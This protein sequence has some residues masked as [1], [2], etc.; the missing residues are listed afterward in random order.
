MSQ[1][2][3]STCSQ[4]QA[5]DSGTQVTF[6]DNTCF[7]SSNDTVTMEAVSQRDG[8]MVIRQSRQQPT[9]ALAATTAAKQ[10]PELWHRRFG[11]LGYDNLFK[12]KNKHMVEGISV[13]AE[14]FKEQQQQKPFCEECTLAKQHRLPF[15][16]S[17]SSSSSL[18][19][20]V[21]MDVCGP[22]QVK[23]TGDARDLATFIDD[24]SRLC[25][26]VPLG[27]KSEAAQAVRA[28]ISLWET[29]TGHRLK[30]VHTDRGTDYVNSELETYFSD[31]GVIHN[32]TAPYTPEQNGVAERFNHTLTKW[33]RSMLLDAKL[34]SEHWADAASTATYVKNRS[35]SSH[36]S[37]TP[38]ELFFGRKPDVS[39]MRVFGSKAYVHVPKQL[40]R[41]LD[42][43][44]TVG[45]FIGYEPNTKAYRV[46][47]DS[48][49]V[50]IS[51]DVIFLERVPSAANKAAAKEAEHANNQVGAGVPDSPITVQEDNSEADSTGIDL[52]P[53]YSTDSEAEE[54]ATQAA[55]E[56]AEPAAE[57]TAATSAQ[58]PQQSRFPQ[59]ERKQPKQIY[60]AQA[61][62]ATELDEPQTYAEAMRAPDAP[63]WKSAMD[64]EMT[65]LQ[66]NS[67]WT[68]EQQ[69]IGVRPIPAKWMFKRKQDALG[70]IERYKAR[71]VAKGFMQKEGIEYNEVFAPVSK[72]TTLRT[73]TIY[74]QQ[75]EGYAEGGPSIVCRLR[76][77]LYG[78][79][80]APRAWNTR[81]KQEL[82]GMGFTASGAD[83]GLF[84]AQ[85]KGSN[86]YI[87]VYVDD[88]L[89][90]AKNLADINHVKARLTDIFDVRS[91]GEA[92][93]FLGMSLDRD[94]QART[95]KMTQERLATELVHK[96]GL[97]EGRTKSVPM[98]TSMKLV[99]AAE[100]QLLD[101]EEYH[102]SE[103][104]GS[105][106]YLSV[107]TRL[108]ISQA[109]GVLARH[110]ARP[111]MGTGQQL[112]Q[113]C[114]T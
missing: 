21:H 56:E 23:S 15:P 82:E 12:L 16:D 13:P 108:D 81:L 61:A 59:R 14:A 40:R 66:E 24:Y 98:S 67:T 103:L 10:S 26:V 104:V 84:T 48:G 86:I 27:Y 65:S 58:E 99:Q 106:L 62:M 91:L 80:Q 2:P 4:P 96:H 94:R 87:L 47:M 114:G 110:M 63:Q 36:S 93:Y 33:V 35:P 17:G 76:K 32:T 54:E 41:K 8:T 64:E 73:Y 85:Y 107:C 90:A 31:K 3:P 6:R 77:S 22:L 39:G 88:I 52:C 95:L 20:L 42:P 92:K 111:S 89:V 50:E 78:L 55:T 49:K 46:L 69:P 37:Q 51:R 57:D 83:A 79:K 29:Q 45:T 30:A 97:K 100:D 34:E 112:R 109:V 72:H 18:L 28:T 43:L 5:I 74:M 102:Y 9:Y 105:L 38:W 25:H 71:L 101:R 7:V 70:N 19:E 75:P 68:L 11:H 113:F 53:A 44:S 1:K 60:K